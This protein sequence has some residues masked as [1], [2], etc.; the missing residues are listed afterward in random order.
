MRYVIIG[1]G[2]AGIT[3]AGNIRKL[4]KDAEIIVYSDEGYNYYVR[5]K[6]ID[7]LAGKVKLTDIYFYSPNWYKENRIDIKL[8]SRIEGIDIKA[9]NIRFSSGEKAGFDRLL[10]AN[11]SSPGIP[12]IQGVDKSGVY[13]MRSFDDARMLRELSDKIKNVIVIGGGILGLE[14]ARAFR[15]HNLNVT[16]IEFFE[17]LLPRQLDEDG[18]SVLQKRIEAMG[19][20]VV[21]GAVTEKILGNDTACGIRLKNGEEFKADMILISA[22]IR[23]NVGLAKE[24][25]LKVNK[26]VIVDDRLK[27][28]A[29]NIYAAG[30]VIEHRERIYGIIPACLEQAKIAAVNMVGKEEI[31]YEGTLPKN[32]LKV[33]GIDLTS[34]G[35]VTPEGPEYK[36]RKFKDEEKG[37]YEKIVIDKENHI[38]GAI[39]LG[40]NDK[41]SRIAKFISNKVDI[42][43][44]TPI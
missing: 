35:V 8:N 44:D 12:P 13:T 6:L 17:R 24:A 30:D 10:L 32:T 15:E 40:R 3:A 16:V 20:K 2:I 4:D 25:G 9:G 31:L 42:N 23:P 39:L 43:K 38:V 7:Y 27:T 1:N 28:S 29:D 33:V 26:G 11:G 36:E 41:V 19:I 21:L 37:I 34:I 18:A 14:C 5:P 22:G